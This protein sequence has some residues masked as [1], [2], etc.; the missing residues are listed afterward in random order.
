MQAWSQRREKLGL[1]KKMQV[2]IDQKIARSQPNLSRRENVDEAFLL[3]HS[4]SHA[5]IYQLAF[6]CGYDA[7]SL[8]ERLFVGTN[9][10]KQMCG[11]LIYTASGDSEGSLGGLVERETRS[12]AKYKKSAISA[13]RFVLM[14][15][16]AWNRYRP[17]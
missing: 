2:V 11:V 8:K 5:L 13:M 17:S 16:S 4:F 15:Q 9:E 10:G 1:A 6:E 3:V 14:T 12:S 7:S